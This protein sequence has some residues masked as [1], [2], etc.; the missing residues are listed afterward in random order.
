MPKITPC[1]WFDTQAEEAATYYTSI[2]KNSRVTEVAYY[3]EGGP[4]PADLALIVTFELDGQPFSALNGGPE[5]TFDEAISFQ[6][7]CAD[8][9]ECDE[10]WD[11]LVGDGGEESQCGWVKDRFGVSWQ[12]VPQ[13]VVRLLQ[14]PDKE[15]AAR[16]MAKLMTMKKIDVAAIEAAA[17]GR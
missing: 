13:P 8:Q 3:G 7:D 17:D 5:F 2:F 10:Y 9:A 4:R 14:D 11:R 1:L 6:I 12:I 16:A 15:R